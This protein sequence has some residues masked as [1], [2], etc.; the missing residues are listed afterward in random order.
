[1]IFRRV[2]SAINTSSSISCRGM[3]RVRITASRH[4]NQVVS[5]IPTRLYSSP[6]SH[7][8]DFEDPTVNETVSYPENEDLSDSENE[9][10]SDSENEDLSNFDKALVETPEE[11]EDSENADSGKKSDEDAEKV[12]SLLKKNMEVEEL[13]AELQTLDLNLNKKLV[14]K[15]IKIPA[16]KMK[17]IIS[18]LQWAF[19]Q[20]G[21]VP[22][23]HELVTLISVMH[24]KG[25][26]K[27]ELLR[28]LIEETAE[29]HE[30]V[31]NNSVLNALI[32]YLGRSERAKEALEVFEQFDKFKCEP[33]MK[34]YYWTIRELCMGSLYDEAWSVFERMDKAGHYPSASIISKIIVLFCKGQ[35]PNEAH[36]IYLKAVENKKFPRHRTIYA[37]VRSLCVVA[38]TP[39][40]AAE[41]VKSIKKEN[42]RNAKHVRH[43]CLVVIQSFCKKQQIEEAQAILSWMISIGMPPDNS[44]YNAL[45]TGLCKAEKPD[46]AIPLL[47]EMPE[48]HLKPDIYAYN[49]IMSSYAK[50]GKMEKACDVFSK[51]ENANIKLHFITYQILIDGF[52]RLGNLEKAHHYFSELKKSGRWPN[53]DSYSKLIRACCIEG[54]DWRTAQTLLNEMEERGLSPSEYTRSLV[55]AMKEL[56]EDALREKKEAAS[57]EKKVNKGEA[58]KGAK[59]GDRVKT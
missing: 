22:S 41:I 30:G 48:R 16:V 38:E 53:K 57:R 14:G 58:K 1:L 44:I 10:L 20:P 13:E 55:P 3:T 33:G 6:T 17:Q 4:Q 45:I 26:V 2:S 40:V 7:I 39:E 21:Y 36:A 32:H 56:E 49:A 51:V 34:S 37:L 46:E 27:L 28:S 59:K 8:E 15:V 52:C 12:V 18:F 50:A 25:G 47:E 35:R 31:I 19:K 29:N 24:S 9:D 43:S 23:P 54:F 42:K 11:Q 5:A